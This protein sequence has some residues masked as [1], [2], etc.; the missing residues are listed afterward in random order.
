MGCEPLLVR[1][2]RAEVIVDF[3]NNFESPWLNSMREAAA[4]KCKIDSRPSYEHVASQ[5]PDL[6]AYR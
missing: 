6:G 2:A 4:I 3:S 5:T 1:E